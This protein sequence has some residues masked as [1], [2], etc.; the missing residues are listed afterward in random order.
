MIVQQLACSGK[1]PA[2]RQ[3]SPPLASSAILVMCVS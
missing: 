1:D 2:N 3:I